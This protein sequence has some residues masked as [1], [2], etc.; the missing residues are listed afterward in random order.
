MEDLKDSFI[1]HERRKFKVKLG[2]VI[3]SSLS[4]FLAGIIVTV[5]VFLT[6]FDVTLKE[7]VAK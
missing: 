1:S 3:A 2:K 7:I 4:G 5:I 6:V